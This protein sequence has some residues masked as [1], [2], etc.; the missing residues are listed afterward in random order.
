MFNLHLLHKLLSLPESRLP[1]NRYWTAS[2]PPIPDDKFKTKTKIYKQ[3]Q[4]HAA[5]I[6][7]IVFEVRITL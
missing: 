7:V 4:V 3:M 1:P 2:C 6:P 5:I